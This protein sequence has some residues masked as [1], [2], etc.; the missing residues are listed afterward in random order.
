MGENYPPLFIDTSAW[1]A[2][3]EKKDS[4]HERAK[5][6]VERNR[7]NE[8]Y[9]G[10]THTSEMVLQETY[11]FLLYN[12]NYDAGVDV[13][14]RIVNSN[15]II[16]P[17]SSLNFE[18]IWGRISEEENELSFV[19]WSTAIYMDRYDIEHIFTF[20]GDFEKV[21]SKIMP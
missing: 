10:A 9:F 17:F 1:V 8:L 3:N 16:H 19:D 21:G 13:V 7:K 20:D 15:V 5:K 11:S 12:Y 6:F 14:D 18:E 2:L 4:Y